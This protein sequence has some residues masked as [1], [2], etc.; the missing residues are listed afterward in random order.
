MA[1]ILLYLLLPYQSIIVF[2]ALCCLMGIGIGFWS[3]GVLMCAEQFGTNVRSTATTTISNFSRAGL[4]VL[5]VL[6]G[7]F[8]HLIGPT[9]TAA[10]LGIG[11][12]GLAMLGVYGLEDTFDKDVDYLE[13]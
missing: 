2:Y 5:T 11:V 3:V 12:V 13:T 6:F 1:A 10:I 9:G 7:K 8:T 4:L